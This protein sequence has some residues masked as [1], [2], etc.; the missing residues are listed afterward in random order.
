MMVNV[1]VLGLLNGSVSKTVGTG[2]AVFSSGSNSAIYAAANA[3]LLATLPLALQATNVFGQ[4]DVPGAPINKDLAGS[5]AAYADAYASCL[6]TLLSSVPY[7]GGASSSG[8]TDIVTGSI[9]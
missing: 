1:S 5:I 6:S 4:E 7:V 3:S 2:T 9:S 8:A